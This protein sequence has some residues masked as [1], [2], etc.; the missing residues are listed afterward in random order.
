MSDHLMLDAATAWLRQECTA[1]V[2][3]AIDAGASPDALAASFAQLGFDD[4]LRAEADGGLGLGLDEIFP[5]FE[6]F[7]AHALPLPAAEQ[8][9]ARALG[10]APPDLPLAHR[11]L[12]CAA[13]LAGAMRAVFDRS[14]A[15]A[16]DRVQFGRPLGKFQAIQHQLAVMA[17]EVFAARMAARLAYVAADL[18]RIDPQRVAVAKARTSEAAVEVAAIAHAVHGAIG[19]THESDLPLFTLRLH[20]WR[21]SAGSESYWHAELGR[22]LVH[23]HAGPT[24]DM[25]RA[26]TETLAVSTP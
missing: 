20:R 2:V 14:L 25:L 19:F 11:A 3:R 17:E 12:V 5:V 21:Q 13:L 18:R 9:V 23:E 26:L 24:L 16:N 6:A 8:M 4:A 10:V 7:G 1:A 22:A 15:Y